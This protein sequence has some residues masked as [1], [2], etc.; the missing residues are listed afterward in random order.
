MF[1]FLLVLTRYYFICPGDPALKNEH[2]KEEEEEPV[3]NHPKAI[4]PIK[5]QPGGARDSKMCHFSEAPS[6]HSAEIRV[7]IAC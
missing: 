1:L 3:P 5:K 6:G 7:S 4:R 2:H